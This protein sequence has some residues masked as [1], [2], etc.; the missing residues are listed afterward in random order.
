M[1]NQKG[2]VTKKN[3]AISDADALRSMITN[4][5]SNNAIS[6]GR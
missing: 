3:N 4:S 5:E 6:Y 1:T 2:G